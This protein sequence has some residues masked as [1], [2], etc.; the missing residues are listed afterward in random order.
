MQRRVLFQIGCAHGSCQGLFEMAAPDT[1]YSPGIRMPSVQARSPGRLDCSGGRVVPDL[2]PSFCSQ[3]R[4]ARSDS[5]PGLPKLLSFFPQ[6]DRSMPVTSLG[7]FGV[8]RA[9]TDQTLVWRVSGTN[10]KHERSSQIMFYIFSID[11]LMNRA[12]C[13]EMP[14]VGFGSNLRILRSRATSDQDVCRPCDQ[15]CLVADDS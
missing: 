7:G 12:N 10:S 11:T 13:V 5:C 14:L 6:P 4:F 8:P 1:S 9:F 15:C 2:C 3:L